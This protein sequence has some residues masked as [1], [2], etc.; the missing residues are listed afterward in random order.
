M[1][2]A[3]ADRENSMYK[4]ARETR[5]QENGDGMSTILKQAWGAHDKIFGL[6]DNPPPVAKKPA[7]RGNNGEPPAGKAAYQMAADV[8]AHK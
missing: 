8:G 6:A 2:D 5:P 3:V 7:P 4:R 1:T